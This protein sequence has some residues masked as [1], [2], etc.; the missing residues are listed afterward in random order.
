M[1]ED[2][3]ENLDLLGAGDEETETGD[4]GEE[5]SDDSE[6]DPGEGEDEGQGRG[7]DG[8][9]REGQQRSERV[10]AGRADKRVQAAVDRA[11]E[12]ER[13]A[14]EAQT[15]L[16]AFLAQQGQR[17]IDPFVFARQQQEEAE[18]VALMSGPEQ[19]QYYAQKVQQATTLQMAQM[20]RQTHDQLDRIAFQN[21]QATHPVA[22][23][24]AA[25]V[26]KTVA[27]E[28][29][30]GSMLPREV[31]L[32]YVIGKHVL[33]NGGKAAGKQRA[34]GAARV[35]AQTTRRGA[36]QSDLARGNT[37]ND[38]SALERRLANQMI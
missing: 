37:S 29:R 15:R 26:E 28:A 20:Q 31:A 34:A 9:P 38:L 24:F 2:E 3:L 16:D 14:T 8:R 4:G 7:N 35:Q 1:A 17:Q 13:K 11:K 32:A 27:E 18:R 30:K 21:L 33:E 23:R 5:G 10:G 6:G 36:P 25:E 19:A 22:K 12:A